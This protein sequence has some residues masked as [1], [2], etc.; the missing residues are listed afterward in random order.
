[1]SQPIFV[2]RLTRAERAAIRKVR[3]RPPSLAVY[4]RAQAIQ[5]SS[6]RLQARQIAEIVSCSPLTVTRWIHE[7]DGHG[8]ATLWPGKS[9]GRPPKADAY[10]HWP[11]GQRAA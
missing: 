5:L 11:G 1:M 7:F 8:L 10:S 9:T 4:R 3:R 2:R 6:Q